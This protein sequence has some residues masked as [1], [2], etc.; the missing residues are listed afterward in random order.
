MARRWESQFDA[1]EL[2]RITHRGMRSL[3]RAKEEPRVTH[4][5]LSTLKSQENEQ[6]KPAVVARRQFQ[7]LV[8]AVSSSFKGLFACKTKKVV[9][10]DLYGHMLRQGWNGPYPVCVDC[11]C[12]ITSLSMV[13]GATPAVKA[14]PHT[15]A[16]MFQPRKYVK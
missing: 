2:G 9:Q 14:E 3:K 4:Q 5:Q 15:D 8:N 12:E 16:G 13:R 6:D 1:D 10:C 11:G 7:Q